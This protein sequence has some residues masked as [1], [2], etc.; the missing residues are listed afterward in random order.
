[1]NAVAGGAVPLPD[2]DRRDAATTSCA[3]SASRTASSRR[4]RSSSSRARTSAAPT[5]S[6]ST[7]PLLLLA[8]GILFLILELK[9]PGIGINGIL[10]IALPRRV[11]PRRTPSSGGVDAAITIGLLLIGFLLLLVEVVFLPGFGVPGIAR[12]RPDPPQHLRREHRP[13]G[14]HAPRAAHPRQRRGLP[15]PPGMA[16]PVPRGGRGRRRSARS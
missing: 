14:R 11:L 3:R 8:V 4:P 5:G 7:G 6:T 15:P 12:D 2:Q 10:G 16:H 9:T 1:M 13:P